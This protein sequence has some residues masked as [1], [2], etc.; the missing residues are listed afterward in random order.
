MFLDCF[1]Y[2][3]GRRSEG[4]STT[5]AHEP[6]IGVVRVAVQAVNVKKAFFST[7]QPL[8]LVKL[9]NRDGALEEP[10]RQERF[11]SIA[12]LLCVSF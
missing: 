3:K 10:Q 11:E 9:Q 7:P 12:C 2:S 1:A 4:S 8:A 6:V 5:A